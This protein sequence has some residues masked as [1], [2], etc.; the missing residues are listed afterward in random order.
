M[1]QLLMFGSMGLGLFE[2]YLSVIG[3]QASW[4]S[5]VAVIALATGFFLC[6]S[7]VVMIGSYMGA[8]N[9]LGWPWWGGVLI[10]CPG[11]LFLIPSIVTT[12][13]QRWS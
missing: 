6:T 13:W 3:L 11:L 9:V 2:L 1:P 7:L 12:L 10:A 4:G 5:V 8:V